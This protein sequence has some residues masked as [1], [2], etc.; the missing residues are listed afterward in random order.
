M[1]R[2]ARKLPLA[3]SGGTP[4][5]TISEADWQRI[6][7]AYGRQLSGSVRAAIVKKMQE[8]VYWESFERTAEA[9]AKTQRLIDAYKKSASD[10]QLTILADG[11]SAAAVYARPLQGNILKTHG[12]AVRLSASTC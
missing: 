6:E 7:G 10:F 4:D 9:F 8:F 12:S 5:L 11:S 1:A 3:R 2:R